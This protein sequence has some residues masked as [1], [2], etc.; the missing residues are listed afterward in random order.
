MSITTQLARAREDLSAAR[1][2][3]SHAVSQREEARAMEAE[4]VRLQDRSRYALR[5]ASARMHIEAI[6]KEIA[7][8]M[9]EIS[10]LET[11]QAASLRPV[12]LTEQQMRAADDMAGIES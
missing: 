8:L 12:V 11:A 9:T 5:A 6:D 7:A 10:D 3:R 1:A 4:Q 2:A